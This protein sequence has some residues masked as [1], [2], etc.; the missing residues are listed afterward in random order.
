MN[1][2]IHCL[3]V[4]VNAGNSRSYSEGSDI[5]AAKEVG[6]FL[7]QKAVEKNITQVCLIATGINIMEGWRH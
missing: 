6:K 4:N 7:A 5:A 1:I 3:C 2:A